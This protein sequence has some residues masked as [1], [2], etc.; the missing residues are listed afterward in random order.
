QLLRSIAQYKEW[1]EINKPGQSVDRNYILQL[2]DHV[3]EAVIDFQKAHILLHKAMRRCSR[4]GD[5]KLE[6]FAGS[7]SKPSDLFRAINEYQDAEKIGSAQDYQKAY[8]NLLKCAVSYYEL[9]PTFYTV[10][11]VE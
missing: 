5:E 3:L 4:W 10:G 6:K 9:I 1:Q 2:A 8:M 7:L 11:K